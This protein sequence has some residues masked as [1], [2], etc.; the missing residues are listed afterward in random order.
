MSSSHARIPAAGPDGAGRDTKDRL[1][2]AALRLFGERGFE[3][4]TLRAVARH[5]GTSVSAANYH[6]GSKEAL[7]QAAL[8]RRLE[9]LNG[10]RLEA[11]D[12]LERRAGGEPVALEAVVDAFLRPGFEVDRRFGGDRAT[13]RNVAAQLYTDPHDTMI[14]LKSRLFEPVIARYVDALAR[15]LPERSREELA[16]DFEFLIGVMIHAISG[17]ARSAVE[18]SRAPVV[19][20]DHLLRR[21]VCFTCAGLRTRSEPPV[22]TPHDEGAA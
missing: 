4:T 1:L 8:L 2:D 9:P 7:L 10:R 19:P 5:A 6:F 20:D 3:G 17:H 18:G 13:F 22:V 12:A 14:S 11:L 15:S 21:M 16:L